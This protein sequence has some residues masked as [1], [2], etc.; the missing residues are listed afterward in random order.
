MRK[1]ELG[2]KKS[3]TQ[4]VQPLSETELP[5]VKKELWATVRTQ[6]LLTLSLQKQV[7]TLRLLLHGFVV[8]NVLYDKHKFSII[9]M[10]RK[11]G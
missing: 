8:S 3:T 6:I 10:K 5:Q 7:S 4:D 9:L 1:L 2:G 11:K